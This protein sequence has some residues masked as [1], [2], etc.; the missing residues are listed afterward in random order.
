MAGFISSDW[1]RDDKDDDLEALTAEAQEQEQELDVDLNTYALQA[2][3]MQLSD[4]FRNR[5]KDGYETDPR[6]KTVI[7]ELE[8]ARAEPDPLIAKL[9]YVVEDDML[10]SVQED[11]SHWLLA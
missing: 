2:S 8:A 9:P 1:T 3:M 7:Q 5:I 4:E 11:G 6:W 10:Y